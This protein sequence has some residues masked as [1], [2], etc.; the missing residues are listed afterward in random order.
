M[1][2]TSLPT[3]DGPVRP[4]PRGD[5]SA[6]FLPGVILAGRY[7]IVAPLGRGGMGEVYRADDMKLGQAVAL[8]FLPVSLSGDPVRR[9]RL[10]EEVRLARQVAHPNVCRVWDVGEVDGHDFLA[11]E[12][13]DGEDLSS[14]LRRIGRLPEDRAVRMSRELCAGLAAVHDEGI[15]HRDLKPANVM[16]DGRG[17]VKLADFGLAAAEEDVEGADVRSGTP[18]YMSPEQLAG[19]E[20]TVRSDVYALGLVL[21][22]LFTG[23]AAYPAKT[24]KEAATRGETPPSRP[25][26]HVQGLDPAIERAI[27]RCLESDAE[28]R[29]ASAGAVAASLPGGD[30]LAAALAAGETPSPE[31]V[32][33]AGGHGGLAVPV[34]SGLMVAVVLGLVLAAWVAD[35]AMPYL[36]ALDK[37]PEVLAHEGR[38]ILQEHGAAPEATDRAYGFTVKE[39]GGGAERLVFWY[40]ESPRPLT[41][42]MVLT[43]GELSFTNPPPIVP[44]MAGVRL[45]ASGRLLELRRV[46]GPPGARPPGPGADWPELLGRTGLEAEAWRPVEPVLIPPLFADQRLAWESAIGAADPPRHAEAA[47]FEGWPVWLLVEEKSRIGAPQDTPVPFRGAHLI[48]AVLLV[49]GFVARRNMRLGRGDHAGAR[50]VAALGAFVSFVGFL[51]LG[52]SRVLDPAML[53]VGVG[54]GL[55]FTMAFWVVYLALEPIVRRRWPDT[56]ASWNRLLA[57]RFSDPLLGRDLL[58]GVLGGIALALCELTGR[59]LTRID[60]VQF[61]VP[62]ELLLGGWVAAGGV[63]RSLSSVLPAFVMLLLLALLRQLLG[64]QWLATLIALALSVVLFGDVS[65]PGGLAVSLPFVGL[66]IGILSRLGL[67][68][69]AVALTVHH[70]LAHSFLTT[71][72]TAWYADSAVAGLMVSLALAAWGLYATTRHPGGG[73]PRGA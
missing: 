54:I 31:L 23:H 43:V 3:A 64:R 30:P 24:M 16:V 21:Y 52:N 17:R 11:M 2:D 14:L 12:Y 33:A 44:G 51:L 42:G 41:E 46:P 13:V 73:A 65:S 61:V 34:A 55:F 53:L 29:P 6:R 25:S 70:L 5:S 19:R 71:H 40:R 49:A 32:A 28:L 26:T 38:Q 56:L 50:R 58:L 18:A 57:G 15:L 4:R 68:A 10:L 66:V 48:I 39:T 1:S 22:E 72:L 47:G 60:S 7:R 35:Q 37:P 62:P 59:A 45:E 27:E 8:K 69:A 20:V 63:V 36:A 67:L 9:E